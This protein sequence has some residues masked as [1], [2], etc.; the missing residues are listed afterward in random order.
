M[1]LSD[2]G[3]GLRLCRLSAWNQLE[4]DWRFFLESPGSGGRLAERGGE[5]VG[6]VAFLRYD[7]N[8]TWLSM[9]LVDPKERR[10]GIGSRL[11]ESALEALASE[12][13]VRLDATPLG[14][15][16]YRRYGFGPE[17]ELARAVA[18]VRS[19]NFDPAIDG[20]EP[21]EPRDFAD[22]FALDRRV[23][24]AD[25]SGLLASFHRRAPGLAFVARHGADVL[26]YCF[27]RPGYLYRQLGPIVAES[28]G[29]ARSL[30]GRCLSGQEGK[31]IAIDVPALAV[32]WTRWLESSGFR[33]ERRFLRMQRGENLSPGIPDRQ[34]AIAGPEFG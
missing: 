29:V 26:G 19:G 34:F 16:M 3:A 4:D 22:V 28:A 25:R 7:A 15:P 17:Y 33:I 32:E 23:F 5:V 21:M 13:C 31:G 27:G 24:G 1:S 14:E 11:M 10:A 9:M 20:V 8:F 12:S 6:S 30:A 18:T 2:T